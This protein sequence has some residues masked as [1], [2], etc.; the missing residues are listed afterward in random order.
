MPHGKHTQS[1]VNRPEKKIGP[2]AGGIGVA[3]WL[4]TIDTRDGPRKVRSVTI[5]P[6]RY[7]DPD[8]G[9]WKDAPSYRPADLPA[10][11]FALQKAQEYCYTTP[12]PGEEERH[13][14]DPT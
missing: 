6:R 11:V 3:V 4:N 2:Y 13:D 8:S 9:E 14:E 1:Q 10:L 5:S 12:L 7:K